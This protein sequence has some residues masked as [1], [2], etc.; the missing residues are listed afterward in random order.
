MRPAIAILR[1]VDQFTPVDG[2]W[3]RLDDLLEELWA[4]GIREGHLPTLFRV[5]ER[6][7]AD[8]GAGVLWSIVHGIEGLDFDYQVQLRESI[9]RQ[10]SLMGKVMLERLEKG[11]AV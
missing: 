1:D 8:D 11:R 3:R 4:S 10:P 2:N 5:F 7:P 6:F 9:A